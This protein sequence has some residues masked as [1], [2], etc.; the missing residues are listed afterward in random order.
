MD[1]RFLGAA[2]TVTGSKYLVNAGNRKV[3][4]DCGLFQGFKHLRLRNWAPLPLD[5]ATLDAVV[6]THAHLDHSGYLPLLVKHGFAGPIYC[7]RAT[8]ELCRILL[9][10]SGRLQEEDAAYANR[11]GFSKHKPALPLYTEKDA[12][13]AL[14]RLTPVAFEQDV[15]LG[16]GVSVRLSPAGH[17]L[18]AALVTLRHAGTSILFSGDLGRQNDLLMPPPTVVRRADYLVVES[19]YGDRRHDPRDPQGVLAEICNRTF[20]RGGAVIVPSFAVGRAQALM[21]CIYLLK[22]AKAIPDVPVYLNSPM[23]VNVTRVFHNHRGEHRLSPA[24]CDGMCNA[25]RYVN[26]VE[27]SKRL[28][29]RHGPMIIIAGSG[30]ATGGR[31]LHHL[32]AFAPEAR[33]TILF[34]GFQAGGTRGA[35]MLNGA[36]SVKIHGEYVPV[37]AEVVNIPNLSGHADSAEI[38]DWLG[39]FEAPPR[40]AFVTHGEP[41]SA[42]ALRHRIEER[43]GWPVKVPDH[44]EHVTLP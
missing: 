37:R 32:T 4:V 6:L 39:R 40:Q 17:I 13:H 44:Q 36:E 30:M 3:L 1:L 24:Q 34:A 5:P 25:A 8:R 18:G 21:Y 23:A 10:D 9:P 16:E 14:R 7:T 2:G 38:L 19:T 43:L 20:E 35:A 27:E 41:T 11:Q 31:V 42:D 28:N 15:D 12:K 33:N 29:T 22:E 26:T